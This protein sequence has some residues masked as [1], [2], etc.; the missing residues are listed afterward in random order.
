MLITA[1]F[2]DIST[3]PMFIMIEETKCV[4]LSI[5]LKIVHQWQNQARPRSLRPRIPF[6]CKLTTLPLS[7]F[8]PWERSANSYPVLQSIVTE[9]SAYTQEMRS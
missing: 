1:A 3:E 7:R 2:L 8:S 9:L 4:S 6:S 5:L